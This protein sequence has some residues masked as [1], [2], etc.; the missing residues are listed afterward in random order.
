MWFD[1]CG[2]DCDVDLVVFVAC[3]DNSSVVLNF[4]PGTTGTSVDSMILMSW[5]Y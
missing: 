3:E 2:H 5:M 1:L 4:L